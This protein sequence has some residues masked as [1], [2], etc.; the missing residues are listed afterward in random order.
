MIEPIFDGTTV[1]GRRI[2]RK[3]TQARTVKHR[4]GSRST[5]YEKLDV[6]HV[7]EGMNYRQW[8]QSLADSKNPKDVSF[9]REMLGPTRFDMVKSGK[10]QVDNLYYAGKLRTIKELK[11]L[12]E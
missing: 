10:L 2:A 11:S 7:P 12:Y 3:E 9:A 4:D 1:E 8:V 5:K 6:D